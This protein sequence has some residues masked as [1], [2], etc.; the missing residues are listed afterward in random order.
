[1][2]VVIIVRIANFR[3]GRDYLVVVLKK[4]KW[5]ADCRIHYDEAAAALE[6]GCAAPLEASAVL[7]GGKQHKAG[8]AQPGGRTGAGVS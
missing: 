3:G 2:G 1:M 6:I 4:D 5:V 8:L 7:C